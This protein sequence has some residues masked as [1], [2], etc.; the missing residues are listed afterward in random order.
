MRGVVKGKL[1]LLLTR[2]VNLDGKKQQLLNDLFALKRRIMKPYFLKESLERS[3]SYRYEEAM[4]RY[5][6]SWIGELRWQ[7]LAPFQKL[8]ERLLNHLDGILNCCRTR[9]RFGVV[10]DINGNFKTLL[11]RCRGYKNLAYLLRKGQRMAVTK[12][13]FIVLQ[14]AA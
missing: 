8:A 11:R 4:L 6:Q 10:K 14:K 7:Q 12:T 13:E 1:W 2:R 3:W 9:V 5:L